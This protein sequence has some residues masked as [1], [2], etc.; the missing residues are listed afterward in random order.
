MKDLW[1]NV[2]SDVQALYGWEYLNAQIE[3]C[4]KL[5]N[6]GCASTIPVTDAVLDALI[7]SCPKSRYLVHGGSKWID[8]WAVS[9]H[10]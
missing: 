6:L 8:I 10:L 7:N 3:G 9:I 1:K 5:G 4:R 2:P